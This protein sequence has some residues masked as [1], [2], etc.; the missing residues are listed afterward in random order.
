[1]ACLSHG[2][3]AFVATKKTIKE[4]K[5]I[6]EDHYNLNY[7][8]GK[9][10]FD[11]V[12][13]STHDSES[14]VVFKFDDLKWNDS[15]PHVDAINNFIERTY[16]ESGL[17]IIGEDDESAYYGNPGRF[18]SST[19]NIYTYNSSASKNIGCPSFMKE[20]VDETSG[21]KL[22]LDRSDIELLKQKQDEFEE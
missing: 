10:D 4:F 13:M 2:I 15:F 18:E 3:G 9:C 7:R 17:V 6:L 14:I 1:M 12:Y 8:T 16:P 21:I 19:S 5:Q 20:K 22:V 11:E